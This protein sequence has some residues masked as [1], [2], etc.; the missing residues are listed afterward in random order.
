MRLDSANRSFVALMTLV[1]LLGM[2]VLCGALGSVLV[3]LV[4]ARVSLI[5]EGAP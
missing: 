2:Y 4:L 5:T 3:P 1:L